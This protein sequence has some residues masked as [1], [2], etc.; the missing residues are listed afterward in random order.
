VR[1]PSVRG[2][3]A[4][5]RARMEAV[6]NVLLVRETPRLC[7]E[8]RARIDELKAEWHKPEPVITPDPEPRQWKLRLV[9]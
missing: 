8:D 4:D 2:Y 3:G 7:I 1:L 9:E 6:G 5:G